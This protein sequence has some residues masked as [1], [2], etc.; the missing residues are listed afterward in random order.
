[1]LFRVVVVVTRLRQQAAAAVKQKV[2]V[3]DISYY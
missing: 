2:A 1:M 3:V